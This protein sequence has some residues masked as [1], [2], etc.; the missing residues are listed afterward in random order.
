MRSALV[1]AVQHPPQMPVDQQLTG[2]LSWR[3]SEVKTTQLFKE[4]H[5]GPVKTIVG[6]VDTNGVCEAHD[7][8]AGLNAADQAQFMARF[9]RYTQIGYL[10][11]PEEMRIIEES[12]VDIRVHEIKTRNGHRPF[13]VE[14]AHRFVASHGTRKP[15]PKAVKKHAQRTREDYR[16]VCER[17]EQENENG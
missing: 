2:H 7:Y 14:E 3:R 4:I 5:S 9:E 13:G 10:R 6:I 12:G 1:Q 16:D 17:E 11:S 8:L 15:K